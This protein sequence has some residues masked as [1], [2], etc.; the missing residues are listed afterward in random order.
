MRAISAVAVGVVAVLTLASCG[1]G[2]KAP[3]AGAGCPS[4]AADSRKRAEGW[5]RPA[6]FDD[7]GYPDAVDIVRGS[8]SPPGPSH[9]SS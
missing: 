9:R 6:D 7:D 4:G 3:S 8:R 5:D 1:T 2:G